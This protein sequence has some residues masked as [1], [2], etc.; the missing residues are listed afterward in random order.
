MDRK[1]FYPKKHLS[2]IIFEDKN[3]VGIK[4]N[5][6]KSHF[7]FVL[8]FNNPK[9]SQFEYKYDDRIELK[10]R[11]SARALIIN[12]VPHEV[13]KKDSDGAVIPIGTGERLFG[14][15]MF[16]GSGFLEYLARDDDAQ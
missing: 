3:H 7:K 15:I 16:T 2:H 8:G 13:F 1:I 4:T 14:Y 12:P 11:K 10:D 9:Y 6:T 5:I